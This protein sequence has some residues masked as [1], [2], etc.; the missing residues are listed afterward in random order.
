MS[1]L[2]I[3]FIIFIILLSIVVGSARSWA[4]KDTPENFYSQSIAPGPKLLERANYKVKLG[5]GFEE[6]QELYLCP[7]CHELN[8]RYSNICRKCYTPFPKCSLCEKKINEDEIF[9]CP[10]CNHSFHRREFLEWLKIKGIC[11]ICEKKIK[12]THLQPKINFPKHL[13]D[14]TLIQCIACKQKIPIDSKFCV[15]CGKSQRINSKI[16][17]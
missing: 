3:A 11:P 9:Y 6:E 13:K 15:F 16:T 12:L 14:S 5:D 2:L 8:S 10:S 1:I 17:H 4:D 7:N